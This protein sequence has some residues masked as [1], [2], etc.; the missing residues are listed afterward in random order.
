VNPPHTRGIVGGYL[1][2]EA[3]GEAVVED[4]W[5]GLCVIRP[6]EEHRIFL[7]SFAYDL[8]E[9]QVEGELVDLEEVSRRRL[10]R[11]TAK[12]RRR[13]DELLVR[14]GRV[15]GAEYGETLAELARMGPRLRTHLDEIPEDARTGN[16][17]A[18]VESLLR[19]LGHGVDRGD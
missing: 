14:L 10:D 2:H 13:A 11:L 16:T 15:G 12:E 17:G 5:K 8:A 1:W 4:S 9:M 3:Q 19:T 6:G 18:G 7:E